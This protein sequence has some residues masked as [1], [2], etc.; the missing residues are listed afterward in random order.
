MNAGLVQTLP[1][2]PWRENADGSVE[3]SSALSHVPHRLGS[4]TFKIAA[5]RRGADYLGSTFVRP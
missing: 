1:D 3:N 5:Q 2:I 4:N